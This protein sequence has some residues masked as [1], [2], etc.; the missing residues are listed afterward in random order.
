MDS[1]LHCLKFALGLIGGAV[2]K[3]PNKEATLKE[4][5]A[6]VS[7]ADL[8]PML[9][10]WLKTLGCLGIFL[11][12]AFVFEVASDAAGLKLPN[13][14]IPNWVWWLI[15][16][17]MIVYETTSGKSYHQVE[18]NWYF[19]K[20]GWFGSLLLAAYALGFIYLLIW[21]NSMERGIES[22]LAFVAVW[23]GYTAPFTAFASIMSLGH[24]NL[25][26]KRRTEMTAEA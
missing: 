12:V 5:L 14:G 22:A 23:V 18:M 21:V 8:G 9:R 19:P 15:V 4:V 17:W 3:E 24:T 13:W 7:L 11:A 10:G 20:Q 16:A 1:L 25:V 6:E 26:E 2:K